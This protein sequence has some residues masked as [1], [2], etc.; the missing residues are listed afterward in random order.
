MKLAITREYQ[1]A[2][3]KEKLESGSIGCMRGLRKSR[4]GHVED[5]GSWASEYVK[6]STGWKGLV[7]RFMLNGSVQN[8]EVSARTLKECR[9]EYYRL[10]LSLDGSLRHVGRYWVDENRNQM[11]REEY[12]YRE[13]LMH[14]CTGYRNTVN[15]E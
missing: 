4:Y 2:Q 9:C 10:V 3:A 12:T 6:T 14:S 1:I 7:G 5:T 15:K 8:H 13:A 11:L